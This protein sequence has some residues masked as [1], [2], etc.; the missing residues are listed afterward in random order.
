MKA[1]NTNIKIKT[2]EIHKQYA[3]MHSWKRKSFH[4]AFTYN[5][6]LY[7]TPWSSLHLSL[8]PWFNMATQMDLTSECFCTLMQ[9]YITGWGK[10]GCS[11]RGS[12]NPQN[13]RPLTCYTRS[14]L[15]SWEIGDKTSPFTHLWITDLHH[16]HCV[17]L[18]H[19]GGVMFFTWSPLPIYAR[20]GYWVIFFLPV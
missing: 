9:I 12:K 18:Q 11:K 4:V 1:E 14:A 5:L 8:K 6:I 2:V 19:S 13:Q 20:W 16:I 10:W 7:V 3:V 17:S 15:W